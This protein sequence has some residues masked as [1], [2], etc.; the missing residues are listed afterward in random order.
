MENSYHVFLYLQKTLYFSFH[1]NA[2]QTL[3]QDST[4]KILINYYVHDLKVILRCS[5]GKL[6]IGIYYTRLFFSKV[7]NCFASALPNPS[8]LL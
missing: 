5:E 4:D 8:V 6:N 1:K 2:W 3:S 7:K